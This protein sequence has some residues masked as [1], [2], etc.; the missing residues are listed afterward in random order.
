MRN[1]PEPGKTRRKPRESLTTAQL[2]GT[3]PHP[4]ALPVFFS[5]P[6]WTYFVFSQWHQFAPPAPNPSE[7]GR[8]WFYSQPHLRRVRPVVLTHHNDSF[9]LH[10]AREP[11]QTHRAGVFTSVLSSPSGEEQA[12]PAARTVPEALGDG[13]YGMLKSSSSSSSLSTNWGQR[14]A[15]Q[16]WPW[17]HRG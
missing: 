17:A 4:S 8:S 12:L 1:V 7:E 14:G 15:G 5:T 2:I 11:A 13:T 9:Q 10:A 16:G 6:N 3:P